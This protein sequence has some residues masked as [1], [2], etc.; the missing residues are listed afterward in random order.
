MCIRDRYKGVTFKN[1]CSGR[2]HNCQP[3]VLL[4]RRVAVHVAL[5]SILEWV[6]TVGALYIYFAVLLWRG[7]RLER[8][9][10][11]VLR[12]MPCEPWTRAGCQAF[13][14]NLSTPEGQVA[15]KKND[16]GIGLCP[17]DADVICEKGKVHRELRRVTVAS[18]GEC[19]HKQMFSS[20]ELF[21]FLYVVLLE[22]KYPILFY[23]NLAIVRSIR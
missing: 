9:S 6:F 22:N 13:S 4:L 5:R 2:N 3:F 10:P 20:G 7:D 8:P 1:N 15:G 18:R 12:W 11:F 17:K 19:T 21:H 14:F 16:I 23:V